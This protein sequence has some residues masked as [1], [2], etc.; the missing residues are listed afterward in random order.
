MS[1]TMDTSDDDNSEHSQ[2]DKSAKSR[3][4]K[5]ED[6]ALKQL[7]EQYGERWDMISRLLKDRTDVQCQQRWTK[8]V[9]PDLIKGPWTK[10]V[11][12]GGGLHQ[13]VTKKT[14]WHVKKIKEIEENASEDTYTDQLAKRVILEDLWV[15]L[16]RSS[17]KGF[18]RIEDWNLPQ[19]IRI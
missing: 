5:H 17:L 8:V 9:N 7:V 19:S 15:F 14:I 16:I 4:T 6:A 3:W 1:G 18:R 10:E 11:S 12:L 13:N 2:G